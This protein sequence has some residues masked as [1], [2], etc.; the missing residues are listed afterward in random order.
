MLTRGVTKTVSIKRRLQI[1]FKMQTRYKMQTAD[2]RLR[3]KLSHRLIWDIFSIYELVV[4]ILRV[5]QCRYRNLFRENFLLGLSDSKKII[6]TIENL[7]LFFNLKHKHLVTYFTVKGIRIEAF[8]QLSYDANNDTSAVTVL[9]RALTFRRS[10][11]YDGGD[12]CKH[13]RVKTAD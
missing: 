11:A 8:C 12:F 7:Y 2:C 9:A 13:I 6:V 10:S 4:I 1:G 5:T 3:P